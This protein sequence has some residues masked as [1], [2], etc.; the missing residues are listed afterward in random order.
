MLKCLLLRRKLYGH[1]Q[2]LLADAEAKR[3]Q[4]HVESC[5]SCR[6]RFRQVQSIIEAARGKRMPKLKGQLWHEFQIELDRKLNARLVPE[7]Q[8]K[9]GLRLNLKPAFSYT[10]VL[11][12]LLV[13]GIYFYNRQQAQLAMFLEEDYIVNE[14]AFLEIV[15]NSQEVANGDIEALIEEV[16][17]LYNT[18]GNLT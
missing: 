13:S 12:L 4:Q 5:T 14:V 10:L 18:A 3:V 9:R 17:F 8:F 15:G 16:E 2:G 7:F 11:I 6:Q 1:A